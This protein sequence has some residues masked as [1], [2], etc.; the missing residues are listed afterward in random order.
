MPAAVEIRE[1]SKRYGSHLAVDRL[2]LLVPA[3]SLFG[4]LGPNGAGKTTTIRMLNDIIA[5]DSGEIRLLDGQRP[6][7]A[8]SRR[9]GY[10]P[11]ERGLYPKMQV[12][13]LLTFFGE[14][15]G[16][17]RREG[18]KRAS[19]WLERLELTDWAKHKVQDLSKGM[20]QK[21]QFITAVLHEPELLILDEPW[22]G[23]D[24]IN[25]DVL[26]EVVR[27]ERK[28]GRTVLFSTHIMEQAERVCDEVCIIS[29]GRKLVEGTIDELKR[30]A[31]RGRTVVLAFAD[32]ADGE[33]AR[34]LL[35][36]RAL[37][38]EARHAANQV[39]IDLAAEVTAQGFLE[40]LIAAQVG[41]RRFERAEPTLHQIFVDR[42]RAQEESAP[43]AADAAPAEE[44][45]H[46]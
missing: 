27:E 12:L 25:A 22:S 40:R 1:V 33:R 15:R 9:V 16:V 44:A 11:E 29:R 34:P 36:D 45:T 20:Q 42:V 35:E 13:E 8:V 6:G 10:L 43:A 14:L 31:A 21:V 38:A 46:D 4:L 37:V 2:S 17:P 19:A 39:E 23:L 7:S 28:K 24:P 26:L 3:G 41:V 30:D 18:A 5:P 32:E